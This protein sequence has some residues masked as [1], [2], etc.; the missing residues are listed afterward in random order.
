MEAAVLAMSGTRQKYHCGSV[1]VMAFDPAKRSFPYSKNRSDISS[2]P[3]YRHGAL[4]GA[5]FP[6][7]AKQS[8]VFILPVCSFQ[9]ASKGRKNPLTD[10]PKNEG[11]CPAFF[12]NF[13][14][15]FL[16]EKTPSLI[17]RKNDPF[18]NQFWKFCAIFFKMVIR[19]KSPSLIS[20]TKR[21]PYAGFCKISDGL[22]KMHDPEPSDCF[23]TY[24]A[25][26]VVFSW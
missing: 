23:K 25:K 18:Y 21:V 14:R 5:A 8:N 7:R 9:G 4:Y 13:W 16:N 20:R 3:V 19:I 6:F 22:W 2:H 15:K 17:S 1:S 12:E 24:C 10:K 11:V 26:P